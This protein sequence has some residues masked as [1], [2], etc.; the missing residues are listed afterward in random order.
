MIRYLTRFI[1]RIRGERKARMLALVLYYV[2]IE[3]GLFLLYSKS[4]LP[5][6]AFVYQ[7]F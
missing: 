1:T 6:P 3:V 2:A 4:H 7:G 5:T